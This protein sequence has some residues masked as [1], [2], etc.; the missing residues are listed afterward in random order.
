M[1]D[2][3]KRQFFRLTL[4]NPLI[5]D[6]TIIRVKE[7]AIETGSANVLIE[8]ISAGGLRF[9]SNVLLPVTPQIILEF[10]T[11]IL[12]QMVKFPGYIVW[13]KSSETGLQEYGVQFTIDNEQFPNITSI[14]HQLEVRLR[15][16]P[17]SPSCRFA[18]TEEITSIKKFTPSS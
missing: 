12:N 6:V 7:N 18:T 11:T 9:T 1:K 4:K 3:E 8:D 13:K 14:L 2:Q 5:S 10:E 15:R 16:S 17:L